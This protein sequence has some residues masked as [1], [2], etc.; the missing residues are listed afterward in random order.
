MWGSE[1]IG[2]LYAPD[3]FDYLPPQRRR[4]VRPNA[5]A[6]LSELVAGYWNK[7]GPSS[8]TINVLNRQGVAVGDADRLGPR[9][10]FLVG[11]KNDFVT[12]RTQNDIYQAMGRSLASWVTSPGLQ[13][14]LDAYVSG[15]W[16]ATAI[17]V[18]D[19]LGLN[20]NEMETPFTALGSA[21]VGLGRDRFR[22]YAAQRLA[23]AAV[24]RLLNRHEEM[25]QRGDERASR[26][27]AQEVAD[28]AFGSFLV[29]SH[30]DERGEENND[31][32]DAIRPE[33]QRKE[34]MRRL[35]DQLF[36]QITKNSPDRGREVHEWR[37]LISRGVRDVIDRKLDEF[38]IAN[39]ERGRVWV[40][41]I[42]Q[43]LRTLAATTL[44]LEGYLVSAMLFRK[45]GDELR[46][47][48]TELEQEAQRYLRHG[49]NIEQAV[50]E[51]LRR[52]GGEVLPQNHPAVAEAVSRGVAAI[53][54][55]GEARLRQLVSSVLPDLA[56][57]VILPMA[58]EVDRA[59]QAL[60]AEMQPSHG[61]PSRISAW[62]DDDDVP[63]RLRPAANEFLL[64]PLETYGDTL[65]DLV[66][67]TVQTE[68]AVGGFRAVVQRIVVG[69]EEISDPTQVLVAQPSHWVPRQHELHAELSTPSRA[70]YD[71]KMSTDELL[72]RA[73][74]WLAKGGTP[75]GNFV[76]EGLNSYL[77]P[78]QVE[79]Q[80]HT[81][82][83]NR[84]ESMFN[85][86]LDAAQP[87]VS[88]K[89][90]V[91]VAVHD[92]NEVPSETFFTELPFAPNSP[93][94]EVV[95]RV[96]ESKGKWNADMEKSFVESDRAYVDAFA[97]L[98]EPYQPVVFE[99]LMRPI[100]EEWG[101]RS[102][103]PDGRE[104]FWRW[105]RAR[106]LTEFIPAA[107]AVRR[108]M[109]RGWFTA[110]MLGQIAFDQLEVKIFVPN[111]VGGDGKWVS[112][113]APPLAAG[114]S[115]AHDYLPLALESLPV[116][117]VDVAVSAKIGP[118][119]PYRR[120]RAVGTS[121]GGGLESYESPNQELH[122]WIE[123]GLLPQGAPTPNP[124]HA[125]SADDKW[126]ARKEALINR[127]EALRHQYEQ[128]FHQ[129]ERRSE[130][131]VA[132][133]YELES[134]ILGSLNDIAHIVREHEIA[135]A[136][137]DIWN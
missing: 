8:D 72:A 75:A 127:A 21:R 1:S 113:P 44:A 125:G 114:I 7:S 117:F 128:L 2:I 39:R 109:V 67:R 80:T 120:L 73:T 51:A 55:R 89:K 29:Q 36:A 56:N 82:R 78:D 93:A 118:M 131:V 24:E 52:A 134:D 102:K 76:M 61:Q 22:D 90:D 42:Q 6:T 59:G 65:R 25:R 115:A 101:D 46:A 132:R 135:A 53:H 130:Q 60:Q 20:T 81:K 49:E 57:N 88:I 12:Y 27:V 9:Y 124:L 3:V 74:A 92:R 4:G 17:S 40:R 64:E 116:A 62:P 50:E 112:F 31:I 95:R 84:F 86:S 69:A 37:A 94:G 32:L 137:T 107:P 105:R 54:Y 71:V 121:A 43:H 45:L 35:K 108:A 16:A 103:T 15:N 99:S 33:D 34:E 77:D 104:E 38:D 129:Q 18:P 85:A 30:L 96:L 48:Q 10:S 23:R 28:N 58:E 66:R 5:L 63:N 110:T 133:A 126:E 68:D 136:G 106:S 123:K 87:L 98:S 19:A 79:P 122:Q 111:H 70:S 13:D 47:V 41:E 14:R 83:L 11:S 119:E 26:A 91:L 97:V 100:A